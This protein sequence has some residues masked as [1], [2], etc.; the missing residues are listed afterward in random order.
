[1]SENPANEDFALGTL[2]RVSQR[3][4]K[5]EESSSLLEKGGGHV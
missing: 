3:G 1:M 2:F 4:Y 5:D